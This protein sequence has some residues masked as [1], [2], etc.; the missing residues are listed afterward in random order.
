[1]QDQNDYDFN[2][3]T[4][5]NEPEMNNS[6]DE[7]QRRSRRRLRQLLGLGV[8]I[9]VVVGA[10]SIIRSGIDL[11]NSYVNNTSEYEQYNTRI[12]PLAWFDI[13]PFEDLESAN[14]DSLKQAAIWGVMNQLGYENINRNERGEPLIPAIEIDRYAA[15]LFG[16]DFAFEHESFSDPVD[17][18]SYTYDEA[19]QIYTA[20]ATGIM[21]DYLPAVVDIVRES[22]GVRRVIVG[23]VSAIG[24]NEELITAP[25]YEH[26]ARFMNYY[27][28][29][30]GNEYYL[31][32]IMPN[33]DYVPDTPAASSTVTASSAADSGLGVDT[34][35]SLPVVDS[36]LPVSS[37]PPADSTPQDEGG[38][39][40]E[41]QDDAG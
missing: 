8:A 31:F 4:F 27:F 13:L 26:P 9:L 33:E 12:A 40:G 10:V 32:S 3:D 34:S 19:T 37:E 16:P 22:G 38:E 14:H 5:D 29:R 30:D 41:V 20:P 35:S 17:G 36:S 2:Q 23:Y 15:A 6:Q 28:R 7:R 18:L 24:S 39:G 11:A 25:D 1:M 21:P